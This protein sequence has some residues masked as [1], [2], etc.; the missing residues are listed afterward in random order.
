MVVHNWKFVHQAEFAGE[1]A[2]YIAMD[3]QVDRCAS[4]GWVEC[5]LALALLSMIAMGVSVCVRAPHCV[6]R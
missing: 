4:L 2:D 5:Q 3:D 6:S 1:S